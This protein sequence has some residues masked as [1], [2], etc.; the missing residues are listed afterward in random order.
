MNEITWNEVEDFD[1]DL[2]EE[3]AEGIEKG[4]EVIPIGLY[5]CSIVESTPIQKDF[6]AYSCLAARLKFK[7][8]QVLEIDGKP[9]KDGTGEEFEGRFVFDEVAFADS[10]GKEKDGMIKR[11]KYVALR[12]GLIEP[13]EK[14]TKTVW[15][16]KVIGR[17]AKIRL[18]KN[19][20]TDK[21]T[22]E[23]KTGWPQVGFFNGYEKVE[24]DEVV[25]VPAWDDI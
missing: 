10:D 20:Y 18:V 8:I 23:K 11:R 16:D 6:S 1:E 4:M 12:L 5:L 24:S 22:G 17:T 15:R 9:V 19:T 2:T 14:L 7:I 13:G 25:E 3:E 21:K